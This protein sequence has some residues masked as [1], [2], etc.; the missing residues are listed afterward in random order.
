MADVSVPS[1]ILFVASIVIA[2]GVAGVLID[3]V[4]GIS[5]ALDDRGADLAKEVRTDVEVISDGG[6]DLY[7]AESTNLT[8]YVKN[9]GSRTIPA[10]PAV[11]DVIIDGQYQ[12]SVSM[13]VVDGDAWRPS[14]VVQLSIDVSL[15]SGDHRVLLAVDG[16]EEV[17]TFRS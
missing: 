9:T 5:G 7:D 4:S 11:F 2:A 3:T 16:D 10:D 15:S 6:S 1:L 14:N 8:V 13:L 12:S 17:F